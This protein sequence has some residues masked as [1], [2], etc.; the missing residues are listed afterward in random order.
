MDNKNCGACKG[1]I[2]A[3]PE[4]CKT[5]GIAESAPELLEALEN[6]LHVARSKFSD[7]DRSHPDGAYQKARA[8]I[9]KA[10]GK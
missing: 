2:S 5:R 9:A 3:H 4:K 1:C 6:M 7:S 10:T 8:A